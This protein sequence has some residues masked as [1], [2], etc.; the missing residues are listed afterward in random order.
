MSSRPRRG[1]SRDRQQQPQQRQSSSQQEERR[2]NS[3]SRSSRRG[4]DATPVGGGDAGD[5]GGIGNDYVSPPAAATTAT[6]AHSRT[7]LYHS[8][9]RESSL[10]QPAPPSSPEDTENEGGGGGGAA[11]GIIM[12]DDGSAATA[13]GVVDAVGGNNNNLTQSQFVTQPPRPRQGL[14]GKISTLFRRESSRERSVGSITTSNNDIQRQQHYRRDSFN[15]NNNV[16]IESSGYTSSGSTKRISIITTHTNAELPSIPADSSFSPLHQQAG[17]AT[18]P[19]GIITTTGGGAPSPPD[20]HQDVAASSSSLAVATSPVATTAKKERSR[21]NLASS[22][23]TAKGLIG[24]GVR[25]KKIVGSARGGH[26]TTT[27][28]SAAAAMMSQS[29]STSS[30]GGIGTSSG[31]RSV[32]GGGGTRSVGDNSDCVS[33]GSASTRQSKRIFYSSHND[34]DSDDS[35]ESRISHHQRSRSAGG[36]GGVGVGAHRGGVGAT[37]HSSTM[38]HSESYTS[39][40]GDDH[41]AVHPSGSMTSGAGGGGGAKTIVRYRGFSTSIKS[42]FLDET[43]VCASMGC[44]GL[45]LS[46]RTEYLLQLRNDRRGVLSPKK[47]AGQDRK[48]LP[49]RIVAYGLLVTIILMFSTFVVWGFGTGS[50]LSPNHYASSYYEYES[51]SQESNSNYYNSQQQQAANDDG[52]ANQNQNQYNQNTNN[53][54]DS[55]K[56][57]KNYNY[58]W[59]KY[60]NNDDGNA[61]ADDDD[62]YFTNNDDNAA[63]AAD[64]QAAADDAVAAADDAVANDDAAAAANDDGAA[65]ANDDAAAAADDYYAYDAGDDGNRNRRRQRRENANVQQQQQQQ[66]DRQAERRRGRTPQINGD[67]KDIVNNKR[68]QSSPLQLPQEATTPLRRIIVEVRHP[69]QGIFKL[70]DCQENMWD[71]IIDFVRDE[72]NRPQESLFSSF[73][74]GTTAATET[75]G[76]VLV[77]KPGNRRRVE[78]QQQQYNYNNGQYQNNNNN[79]DDLTEEVRRSRDMASNIRIALLFA[80]LL[81]LGV[82][83]RRRRM[84]TR[85]YLVRAR[86]QEDHLFYASTD[87]ADSHRRVNFDDTRE[88]QYEGA[89]SHTLCGCYPTDEV[90]EAAVEAVDEEVEVTDKGIFKRKRK[91]FNED[92]VART[93]NCFLAVCCGWLCKCWFQCLSICA[94]AQEAREIRLL[95]P[96]RYQRID[97]ITHQP[98][99]EYQKEVNDLRRGWLGKTRKK[100]GFRPHYMALS[101]LSRYIVI[102]FLTVFVILLITLLFNPRAAFSWQDAVVVSATFLQ[103]F[104]VLFI[105]HWIFHK[106]DLS[107][108]AV[109]KM[110][111]GGFIIAVPAAFFFEALMVNINLSFAW[112]TYEFCA[113]LGGETF[114][115]WVFEHWRVIWFLGELFNA[116]VVAAVTEE[117][118]KYYT[119]RA[120]EHPDLVFLTGLNRNVQN[121][122]AVD[123]GLVKYNRTGNSSFD[124]QSLHSHRSSGSEKHSSRSGK[125]SKL[126]ERTGTRDDEFDEDENDVRTYR[127]KA[128]AITTG[129]ISVAVGLACAENFLYVFVLGGT[130]QSSDSAEE[131][132]R[133][134]LEQWIVLFFRSIFP[135]HALAAALQSINM[136][137]KF[138]EGDEQNGHRIGVGRII[139][140]A[141]LLHGSFDAILMGINVYQ[142]TAWERYM[143]DQSEQNGGTVVMPD[144]PPYNTL[145]VNLVAW[146]GIT[147]VMFAGLG[148]Y[149]RE[150]RNQRLRLKILEEKEKART[151]EEDA[152]WS[153]AAI[154]NE[155]V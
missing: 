95:V 57:N 7:S 5:D 146:I 24:S 127:Q 44:F 96:P 97:Y 43:V 14:T 39:E 100:A 62:D 153:A 149:Y 30:G 9:R 15:S 118:C 22:I 109:V 6:P 117:L 12:T 11:A 103:A 31:S 145:I 33:V 116:Y 104:L 73:N 42:L 137:R 60:M 41:D 98:F 56:N 28:A 4:R 84:R 21:R 1:S 133:D 20:Y 16:A 107:L 123:G 71:P 83:G 108:D 129:M 135:I 51:S 35:Y 2:S 128:M 13:T 139:F 132:Q 94:L 78:D 114:E 54:D 19:A 136:I 36:A 140:P 151:V 81:F 53:Y 59:N 40:A 29:K 138:V 113:L 52:G 119:F 105:V 148:W 126:I 142:E 3:N 45:I 154:E 79:N 64:D 134:I 26:H 76:I 17:Q 67:K 143:M 68:Q 58:W 66:H 55:Y 77:S 111:A 25:V 120:I 37:S 69:V 144:E 130:K 141:V 124:T 121:E 102:T 85:F 89:C 99:H 72:W 147:V 49:S 65:A 93:F 125:S 152:A 47:N 63:A 46:N 48:K 75:S 88:D 87:V 27:S 74:N 23:S 150:N 32:G 8:R 110:F 38:N 131:Y 155:M 61:A 70:R 112:I 86:A 101:R 106:S 90:I 80:F 10:D 82:L 92:F 34:D 122:D 50:G 18:A 91:P 115:A